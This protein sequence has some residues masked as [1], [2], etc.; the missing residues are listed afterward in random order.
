MFQTGEFSKIVHVSKRLLRFYDE[1]GLFQP[2]K[3]DPQTGYRHYSARQLPALNRILVLKELGLSLDE[4]KR[5]LDDGVSDEEIRS[6]LNAK[7]TELE[8]QLARNLQRLHDIEA[9]VLEAQPTRGRP[10]V[11]VKSVPKLPFLSTRFIVNSAEHGLTTLSL[12]Q[13]TLPAKVGRRRLGPFTV[14]IHSDGYEVE[15]ADIEM[16]FVLDVP[17]DLSLTLA[18]ELVVATRVLPAVEAMATVVVAGGL[19]SRLEGFATLGRWVEDNGYRLAGA[20][21][22]VVLEGIEGGM[23]G[24]MVLE[25]QFPISEARH[26]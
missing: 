10:D 26:R 13:Q 4:V 11:V 14:L 19:A 5:V 16:G 7:R 18:D 25:A 8:R 2:A 20:Q 21:R 1:I 22:E 3:V 23:D 6:L 9:R 12:L 15:Q 24:E 17:T